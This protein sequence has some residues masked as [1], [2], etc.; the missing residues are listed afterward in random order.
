[1]CL[2]PFDHADRSPIVGRFRYVRHS[3]GR[4]DAVSWFARAL[5]LGFCLI[6]SFDVSRAGEPRPASALRIAVY[7]APPYGAVGA[8]G[9]LS[10]VS[11]DLWRRVAEELQ[12]QYRL[13]PVSTMDSVLGGLEQGRFDAAIGAITITPE[14]EA[15][16]D[17]SYPTHR[18]GVAVAL[19]KESGLTAFLASFSAAAEE[20]A[21]AIVLLLAPLFP[22]GFLI[23]RIERPAG[24]ARQA[25]RDTV[26]SFLDG[27]YWA[28]VTM[29]TVGYGDK[30]PKTHLG[31]FVAVV[32]MLCSVA[33][34]TFLSAN[35]VSR[36]T[37]DRV[38]NVIRNDGD[39]RGKKLAAV[40]L[41]SGAE[42]LD[43]LRFKHKTYANLQDALES[44]ARGESNVVVNSEGALR[45]LVSERFSNVIRVPRVQLAPAYMGVALPEGSALKKP[46]DRALIK[47]TESAEWRSIE[48][49]YFGK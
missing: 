49:R 16:V 12:W 5:L 40:A 45:H 21:G 37:A 10:G 39:L 17:F 11:V 48:E 47:I 24:D 15:R 29:T 6:L 1:V 19:A 30:T 35:V 23:W 43:G 27:L 2:R 46:I 42:F 7:D 38:E 18:S 13:I 8:D 36:L 26:T 34:M 3:H 14:R 41:S 22:L 32:W 33:L 20:F 44:L 28:A 9:S 31:R 4:R 25:T